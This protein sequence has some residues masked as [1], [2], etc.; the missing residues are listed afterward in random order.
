MLSSV[1]GSKRTPSDE[2]HKLRRQLPKE[3]RLQLLKLR[4]RTLSRDPHNVIDV[5]DPSQV[6]G[7]L[8]GDQCAVLESVALC[9]TRERRREGVVHHLTIQPSEDPIALDGI[10]VFRSVFFPESAEVKATLPSPK[11][12]WRSVTQGGA[13]PA[14]HLFAVEEHTRLVLS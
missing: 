12:H 6:A 3:T 1:N 9:F 8:H 13:P 4:D 7:D 10:M 11:E 2:V 5:D 14:I